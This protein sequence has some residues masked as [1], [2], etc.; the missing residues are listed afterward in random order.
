MHATFTQTEYNKL[1][2]MTDGMF[3][4]TI[5]TPINPD[6][7]IKFCNNNGVWQTV[8]DSYRTMTSDEITS[9]VTTVLALS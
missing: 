3:Y 4:P 2:E 9:L 1:K 7:T 8:G 5:T 6:T